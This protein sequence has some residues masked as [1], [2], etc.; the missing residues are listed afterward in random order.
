MMNM[1]GQIIW[2]LEDVNHIRICDHI[3]EHWSM[4]MCVCVDTI[5]NFVYCLTS[6]YRKGGCIVNPL[7]FPSLVCIFVGG[8]IHDLSL[9]SGWSAV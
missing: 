2:V 1:K 5:I 9:H 6:P 4:C 3:T 8:L 7:Y